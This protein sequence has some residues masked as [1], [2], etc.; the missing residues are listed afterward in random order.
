MHS[1]PD[2]S[3]ITL[4]PIGHVHVAENSFAIHIHG[5]FRPG[6]EKLDRFSHV[7]VLWWASQQD[8]PQSRRTLQTPLPYA[9]GTVAGVFACRSEFRPNPI[10]VT[11]CEVLHLDMAGGVIT[12]PYID[13]FDATPVLD[14]KPYFPVSER[15]REA[16]VAPWAE[17]WP[18][19]YEESYKMAEIFAKFGA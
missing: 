13:A 19:C 8:A 10:A 9:D 14:L 1:T 4:S 16:R 15:V 6:L 17:E 11:I 2:V 5:A 18:Q 3:R 12:V 7:L